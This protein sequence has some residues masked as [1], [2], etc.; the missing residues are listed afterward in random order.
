MQV[1]S[2]IDKKN[3]IFVED[4]DIEDYSI[5]KGKCVVVNRSKIGKGSI[6]W[7]FIN[8]YDSVIGENNKIASHTEIGGSTTGN[9]CKFEAFVFIPPG[10]KIGNK[11]FLGPHVKLANDK[12]PNSDPIWTIGNVTIE[13]NVKIGMGSSI[14]PDVTIGQ[15]S[16]VAA[17][18]LVTKNVPKD[19]FVMGN[20]A[21][22]VNMEV[23]KK[24]G[25]P[26]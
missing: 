18:S 24:V 22:I 9:D 7:Y 8:I 5:F 13:D 25:I 4:S 23:F 12:Y 20:P 26:I 15:N 3:S 16:F 21:Q 6:L 17:G 11:V 1:K 19:S 10:S 2:Y 14:L